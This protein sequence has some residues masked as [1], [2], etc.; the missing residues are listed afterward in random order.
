MF[1]T[2]TD[3]FTVLEESIEAL[4]EPHRTFVN[5]KF[6]GKGIKSQA[7]MIQMFDLKVAIKK[8]Q[9]EDE[10]SAQINRAVRR[11]FDALRVEALEK[12]RYSLNAQGFNEADIEALIVE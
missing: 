7:D 6:L 9:L 4:P 8:Y 3:L 1:M 12:L 5:G 11:Y 10:T 2:D